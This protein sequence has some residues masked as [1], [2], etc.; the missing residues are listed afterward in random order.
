MRLIDQMKNNNDDDDK[1]NQ[2]NSLNMLY[3]H[4]LDKHF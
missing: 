1:Y 4:T 2:T 3:F